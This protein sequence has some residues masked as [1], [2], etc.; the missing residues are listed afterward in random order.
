V[1]ESSACWLLIFCTV[2]RADPATNVAC[3]P[4]VLVPTAAAVGPTRRLAALDRCQATAVPAPPGPA[5]RH[6]DDR[7]FGYRFRVGAARAAGRRWL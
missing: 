1:D 5:W 6:R 7:E 2:D 3:P 4:G